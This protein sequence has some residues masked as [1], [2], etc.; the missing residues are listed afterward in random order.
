MSKVAEVL[1]RF[2]ST[3]IYGTGYGGLGNTQRIY[4]SLDES[5]HII[6]TR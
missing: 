6:V 1:L 3:K 2:I 4:N 5:E